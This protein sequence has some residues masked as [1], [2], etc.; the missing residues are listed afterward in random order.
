MDKSPLTVLTVGERGM[1]ESLPE[2]LIISGGG[3]GNLSW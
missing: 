2:T 3:M 1:K